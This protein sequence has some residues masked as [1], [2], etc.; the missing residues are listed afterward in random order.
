[1]VQTFVQGEAIG[2]AL[3]SWIHRQHKDRAGERNA[4]ALRAVF[5]RGTISSPSVGT[6]DTGSI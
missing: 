5:S 6:F 4:H 2:M 1:M 3:L